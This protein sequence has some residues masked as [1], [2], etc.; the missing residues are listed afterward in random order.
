MK[1]F[2]PPRE[3]YV[4][5]NTNKLMFKE[6][7]EYFDTNEPINKDNH[8]EI[9]LTNELSKILS[10]YS[11]DEI[12]QHTDIYSDYTNNT[13]GLMYLYVNQEKDDEF[14]YDVKYMINEN[15]ISLLL[16]PSKVY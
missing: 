9:Y 15:S 1:H 4:D 16:Y 12:K 8:Y 5:S 11:L 13:L 6:L 10:G 3:M 14:F 2:L 7:D